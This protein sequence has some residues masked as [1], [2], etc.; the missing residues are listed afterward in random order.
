MGTESFPSG[1]E[2]GETRTVRANPNRKIPPDAFIPF[3]PNILPAT[4]LGR[5]RPVA[6]LTYAGLAAG[7]G[8]T[9][10]FALLGTQ[11]QAVQTDLWIPL[12]A[13]AMLLITS[14]Q[15]LY[16]NNKS[17]FAYRSKPVYVVDLVYWTI[18]AAAALV[19]TV[20]WGLAGAW[21]AMAFFLVG[22]LFVPLGIWVLVS[23]RREVAAV[24]ASPVLSTSDDDA[25]L[26]LEDEKVIL[27]S[28]GLHHIFIDV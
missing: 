25:D 24:L 23:R 13:A 20:G 3:E 6:L 14:L 15:V 10:W 18:V 17:A 22:L 28:V 5:F 8:G 9:V 11:P 21:T 26:D 2:D 1:I 19:N 7:I 4:V 16:Q 27:F 12:W